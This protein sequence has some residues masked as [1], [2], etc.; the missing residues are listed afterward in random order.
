MKKMLTDAKQSSEMTKN[1]N[2]YEKITEMTERWSEKDSLLY[3]LWFNVTIDT[4]ASYGGERR[5]APFADSAS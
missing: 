1:H 3:K 5:D 2:E 4:G